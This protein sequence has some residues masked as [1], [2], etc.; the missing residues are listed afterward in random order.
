MAL[1][2]DTICRFK[3]QNAN[4]AI[5]SGGKNPEELPI[6]VSGATETVFDRT[7][8]VATTAI[9]KIFDATVDLSDFDYLFIVPEAA[10]FI[11]LVV[12]DQAAVGELYLSVPTIANFPFILPGNGSLAGDGSVALFDGT[13]DFIETIR[14]KNTSAATAKIRIF[15]LT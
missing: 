12:D 13:A 10:G 3:V 9:Q 14:W 7:F 6:R 5:H 11:E 4:G 15:A 8:S 2:V 1:T